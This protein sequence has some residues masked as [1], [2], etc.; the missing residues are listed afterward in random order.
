METPQVDPVAEIR[1]A[2]AVA[3]ELAAIPGELNNHHCDLVFYLQ[4]ALRAMPTA[5]MTHAIRH[6]E[7]ELARAIEHGP[8]V[9]H[10]HDIRASLRGAVVLAGERGGV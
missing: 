8:R 1:A 6:A 3:L 7:R 9:D 2:L 10:L 5:Q 4:N